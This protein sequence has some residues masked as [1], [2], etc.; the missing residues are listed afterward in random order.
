M[1]AKQYLEEYGAKARAAVV[2]LAN[3]PVERRNDAI[4]KLAEIIENSRTKFTP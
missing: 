3:S 4:K 1:D 2:S